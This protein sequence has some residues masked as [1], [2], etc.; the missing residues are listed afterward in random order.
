MITSGNQSVRSPLFKISMFLL[1]HSDYCNV[2]VLIDVSGHSLITCQW[3]SC[4]RGKCVSGLQRLEKKL[5]FF[6]MHTSLGPGAQKLLRQKWIQIPFIFALLVKIVASFV[7]MRLS[8]LWVT[9]QVEV[10]SYCTLAETFENGIQK[11][12]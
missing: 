10:F 9:F 1:L 2:F 8:R 12:N 5:D 11:K 3:W 6:K 7:G 4:L